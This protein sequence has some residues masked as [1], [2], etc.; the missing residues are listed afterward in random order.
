MRNI[1]TAISSSADLYSLYKEKS[2]L[3]EETDNLF[4]II[5]EQTHRGAQLISNVQKLSKIEES[6]ITITK[7]DINLI[8]NDAI[9][10][11]LSSYSKLDIKINIS[12]KKAKYYA[13]ANE[14]LLD[15]F[16][17]ILI[18]SIKHNDNP[19]IKIQIEISKEKKQ[20]KNY[21]KIEF[22]DNGRGIPDARKETIFQRVSN[23][24]RAT[25]GMGLGLSL[26]KFI[27]DSYNGDILVKD[28]VRGNYSKGSN[29][30]VLIPEA[31]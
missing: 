19:A 4:Q 11:I 9:E 14:L 25:S 7:T 3:S 28:R 23:Q 24:Q 12:A 10:F 18:N 5:K 2:E 26:V 21:L 6:K 30:I 8:L 31:D 1:L 13:Q 17:N 29:F 15:A 27:I 20:K 16:E 22:I